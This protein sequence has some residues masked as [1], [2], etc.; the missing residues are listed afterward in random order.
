M[1]KLMSV[2]EILWEI[3]LSILSFLFSRVLRFVMQKLLRFYANPKK[4]KS[5][6]WE[7]AGTDFLRKPIKLLWAMTRA[8]WNLHALIAI[9]GPLEVKESISLDIH[10]LKKSAKSWTIVVYST[11][12][13]ETITSIGSRSIDGENQWES[14]SVKPGTYLLGSRY[15][16]WAETVELPA[17]KVDGVEVV[18]TKTL[19]AP[20]N[21]NDF[22]HD[23]IK[24]KNIIHVCL[25]YYVFN[26]LRFKEWLP[27]EFVRKVFLPVPNPETKFYY[28]AINPGNALKLELDPLILETH[29]VY[30]SLLNRDCFPLEWYTVNETKHTTSQSNAKRIYLV[31]VHQK[32]PVQEQFSS[33][34]VKLVIV[35]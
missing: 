25:N 30:L 4:Q 22:H 5:P 10:S 13:F 3:P 29:D 16:H 14:L 7:I 35:G 2:V 24:R 8:R 27:H 17:V 6:Q 28:G 12:N 19:A 15:Y 11:A 21:I 18:N 1:N 32:F 23:L 33:D 31:R 9:V 20:A 26:L 34:W